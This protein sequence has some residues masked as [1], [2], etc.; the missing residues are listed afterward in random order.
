MSLRQPVKS[1][2]KEAIRDPWGQW[3][4]AASLKRPVMGPDRLSFNKDSNCYRVYLI[5]YNL[6]FKFTIK[7]ISG[8]F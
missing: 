3:P 1:N 6:I 4:P 2:F 7:K 5:K 8:D